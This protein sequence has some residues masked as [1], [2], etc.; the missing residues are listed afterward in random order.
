MILSA[1]N[2]KEAIAFLEQDEPIDIL[3]TDINLPGRAGRDRW[4]RTSP[5]SCQALP[6]P[7][8]DLY[9]RPRPNRRHDHAVC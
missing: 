6:G 1:A 8:R 7:A 3:F 9:N 4:A 2:A 5:E